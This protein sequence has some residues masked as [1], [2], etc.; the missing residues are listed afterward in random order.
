MSKYIKFRNHYFRK[1]EV[2]GLS[3][4]KQD[5]RV[6]WILTLTYTE[7]HINHFGLFTARKQVDFGYD[8]TFNEI[9]KQL[10]K[11]I[12]YIR[13]NCDYC[14]FDTETNHILRQLNKE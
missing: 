9:D 5:G 11:D 14:E 3:V 12:K 8:A 4:L 10:M 2:T 13:N 6:K 7:P 1:D